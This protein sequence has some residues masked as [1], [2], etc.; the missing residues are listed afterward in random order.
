MRKKALERKF[1]GKNLALTSEPGQGRSSQ[2]DRKWAWLGSNQT[3][4]R[5]PLGQIA[6]TSATKN[7]KDDTGIIIV[8]DEPW[9]ICSFLSH[10]C[11]RSCARPRQACPLGSIL[12]SFVETFCRG[13]KL[14][15]RFHNWLEWIHCKISSGRRLT[16][17]GKVQG[18]S[19]SWQGAPWKA[20]PQRCNTVLILGSKR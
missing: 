13:R 20:F 19:P 7:I 17:Q 8:V 5:A 11:L 12:S 15:K 14:V 1:W 18:S 9:A 4:A 2:R 3:A 10:I 6:G 16:S